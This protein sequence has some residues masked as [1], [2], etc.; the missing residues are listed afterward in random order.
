MPRSS[1][2]KYQ[3]SFVRLSDLLITPRIECARL[4][5]GFFLLRILKF[6][7]QLN[8]C[9]FFLQA[10]R[11]DKKGK[12]CRKSHRE[13]FPEP[14]DW[15]FFN[16]VFQRTL[17]IHD[18]FLRVLRIEVVRRKRLLL[19]SGSPFI[20][21]ASV[22]IVPPKNTER[23]LIGDWVIGLIMIVKVGYL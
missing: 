1:F 23:A 21:P 7:G 2:P 14:V 18:Y 5:L 4:S 12:S 11:N 15:V 16:L 10:I 3:K 20:I 9:I 22:M 6:F 19:L 13:W 8:A 17:C